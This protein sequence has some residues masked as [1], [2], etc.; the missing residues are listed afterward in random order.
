M[1]TETTPAALATTPNTRFD[2]GA[3]VPFEELP[4]NSVALDGY[5]QGPAVDATGRRFSF[6]HHAGCLRM[7]TKATCEQVREAICL[8]LPID[9]ETVVYVNDIDADTVLS[10][11]LLANPLRAWEKEVE[12]LVAQIGRTDA[13]GPIFAAHPLHRE[14]TAPWGKDAEP[15]STE[16]L[17][18]FVGKVTAFLAGE[19]KIAERPVREEISR[20]YGWSACTGWKPVE[21]STAFDGFY[22]AG[23]VLGFLYQEARGGGLNYTVAKASDLVAAP[24]GPGSKARP[25]TSV[26]QFE[27]TILGEL[28]RAEQTKNPSQD[29]S[30]TWGGGT[31]IGGG[32][33]NE[34][35]SSSCLTPEEVLGVFQRFVA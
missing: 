11:W 10:V 31:S 26:E 12:D 32:P 23:F 24:L 28:G 14:I 7:V 3:T 35:D 18:R 19:L 34:D 15:Q 4:P 21:S 5:C 9:G 2:K 8:G 25:V 1:T 29:L 30:R 16:M 22:R 13:H 20:G 17:E 6:D 33:R 27:E